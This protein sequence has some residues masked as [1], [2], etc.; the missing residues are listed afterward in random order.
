[1]KNIKV[2]LVSLLVLVFGYLSAISSYHEIDLIQDIDRQKS[3][4]MAQLETNLN[5]AATDEELYKATYNSYMFESTLGNFDLPEWYKIWS[6]IIATVSLLI[7]VVYLCAGISLLCLDP[8]H[9]P[10]RVMYI[11]FCASISWECFR[12]MIFY[13]SESQYL[14]SEF[15]F[16]IKD[17]VTN[18][19]L[20]TLVSW[21][22]KK[23]RE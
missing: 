9:V 17:V 10:L 19:V 2:K 3:T 5:Q 8:L 6:P 22:I 15:P 23:A 14:S 18:L 20:L 12:M 7:A 13:S 16:I 11:L 21:S 1:M 4:I